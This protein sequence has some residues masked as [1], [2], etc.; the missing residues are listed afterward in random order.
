MFML[1]PSTIEARFALQSAVTDFIR[2]F[3]DKTLP[4]NDVFYL[5]A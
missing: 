1:K 5:I 2:R 4:L 3:I